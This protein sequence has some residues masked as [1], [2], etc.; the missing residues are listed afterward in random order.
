ME[1]VKEALITR[2]QMLEIARQYNFFVSIGTIHR[3][4]NEP[5]F[6]NVVGKKGKYLLYSHRD[7]TI[8]LYKRM[9]KIQVE[10]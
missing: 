3:W 1:N 9:R 6:P 4:A 2:K 5:D 7:F 10:H 8:F